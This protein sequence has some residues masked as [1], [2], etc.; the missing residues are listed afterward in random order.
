MERTSVSIPKAQLDQI[1]KRVESGEF[2]NQSE[3]IR[4]AVREYNERHPAAE[5]S[6]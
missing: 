1:S 3:F 4:S 6:A 5:A 2:P